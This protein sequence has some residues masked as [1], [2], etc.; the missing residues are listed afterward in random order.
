VTSNDMLAGHLRTFFHDHLIGQRNVSPHTV[1]AYRDAIK[2]L[3]VFAAERLRKPVARLAFEDLG[4]ETVLG[5]L[6]HLETDR[7]NS[8]ATRNARLAALHVFYHHVAARDPM[9]FALCQRV[10]GIPLKRGPRPEVDYLER[11]EMNAILRA[12]DRATPAG[13][14]DY[15]LISFAWQTGARVGEIIALRA[16]DL[17]LDP[18]PHVR[19]WGKGRKERVIPLWTSTAAVLRAWL[20][21]RQVDPRS[22]SPVFVNLRGSPLTRWGVRHILRKQARTASS[23]CP[24]LGRK[25]VHPHILRHTTAVHMLQAGADPSAIRDVL[26]H[27]SPETTWKYARI[28][29]EMKR[30]A[31][32]SYAPIGSKDRSPVPIWHRQPDLLAELEAIGRR[33]DYVEHETSP[34]RGATPNSP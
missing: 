24:N 16:C 19:I 31:V 4:V 6:D 15:A 23:G 18:L 20:E 30:Q 28:N 25:A 27:A 17:Q 11:E 14:R 12:P 5:F 22:P 13:R 7:N 3:L 10:L 2:L 8:V 32:E 21:E 1:L 34:H 33:R 9:V 29:L 26:G